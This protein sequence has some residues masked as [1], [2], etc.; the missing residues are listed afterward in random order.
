M[1]RTQIWCDTTDCGRLIQDKK[2]DHGEEDW[3][4]EV[5]N[6][7]TAWEIWSP[8]SDE[9]QICC[10]LECLIKRAQELLDSRKDEEHEGV[11]PSEDS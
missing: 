2:L 8:N 9:D 10:S 7:D 6:K 5:D 3:P 11:A 1:K 4:L